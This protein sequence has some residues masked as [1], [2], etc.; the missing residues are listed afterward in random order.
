MFK[1]CLFGLLA[2]FISHATT[3]SM[4]SAR[5]QFVDITSDIGQFSPAILDRNFQLSP[6]A[7]LINRAV[8]RPLL[9]ICDTAVP[10]AFSINYLISHE[11][12]TSALVF[13]DGGTGVS[14]SIRNLV[15]ESGGT[16]ERLGAASDGLRT[17][18][19]A[20]GEGSLFSTAGSYVISLI[21]AFDDTAT[22]TSVNG[23]PGTDGGLRIAGSGFQI[24][25]FTVGNFDGTDIGT[26]GALSSHNPI[27]GNGV[28]NV[29]FSQARLVVRV[30]EPESIIMVITSSLI[31]LFTHFYTRQRRR[32]ERF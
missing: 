28:R 13:G 6:C 26:I 17:I 19:L 32:S 5:Q 8:G 31:L 9:G 25:G 30:P 3:S 14:A 16:F 24:N 23:T 29:A 27:D 20:T 11:G 12:T 2:I 10:D 18:S 21:T 4:V 1:K 15:D 22:L 7:S